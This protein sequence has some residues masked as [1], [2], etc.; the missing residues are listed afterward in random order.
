MTAKALSEEVHLT[1][2]AITGIVD[3]LEKAGYVKRNDNPEDRRSVLISP[4]VDERGLDKKLG[5]SMV[6]YRAEMSNLFR[7]YDRDQTAVI[8]DF[9]GEFMKVLR[10]QTSKLRDATARG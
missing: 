2:G 5:D 4:L 10:E 1:T 6:A 7:K 3:H 9:L 8:V